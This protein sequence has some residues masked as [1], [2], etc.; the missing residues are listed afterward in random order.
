MKC[1]TAQGWRCLKTD[2]PTGKE[3]GILLWPQLTDVGFTYI[4][5]NPQWA[6]ANGLNDGF[7]LWFEWPLAPNHDD[8]LEF[9]IKHY[10][11]Y[12]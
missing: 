9:C 5:S 8:F 10:K 6:L 11:E 1:N 12:D 4:I 2:P 3:Y 7:T